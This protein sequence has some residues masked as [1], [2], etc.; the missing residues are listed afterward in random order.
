MFVYLISTTTTEAPLGEYMENMYAEFVL[1]LQ[2]IRSCIIVLQVA[3]QNESI[4]ID[5]PDVG[6]NLE[7]IREKLDKIIDNFL[8]ITADM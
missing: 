6:N 8:D 2:E 7:I 3:A 4:P 1:Q 5:I